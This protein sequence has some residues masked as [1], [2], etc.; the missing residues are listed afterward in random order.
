MKQLF[1]LLL[2]LTL[3]LPAAAAELPVT[4][5]KFVQALWA[6]SGSV[7]YDGN[8]PFSDVPLDHPAATAVAWAHDLGVVRGTGGELFTPDRP[9]T[10]EEA[11]MLL[12][13]YASHLGRDTFL[14][15]GPSLCNDN[16]GISPWAD[17]SL[18]WATQTGL[19]EWAP[20]GLLDPHGTFTTQQMDAVLSRFFDCA[21]VSAQR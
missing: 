14:P 10:R 4:R 5:A 18:Y 15:D 12:R 11:A 9:I 16:E 1:P 6:C 20:G 17:D 7:P 13:R 19:L 21:C 2:L 3:I 8:G